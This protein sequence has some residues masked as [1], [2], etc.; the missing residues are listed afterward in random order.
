[1][2]ES[3]GGSL[4]TLKSGGARKGE[5]EWGRATHGWCGN[6]SSP[7]GS[8]HRGQSGATRRTGRT[9]QKGSALFAGLERGP[10][11]LSSAAQRLPRAGA[12]ESIWEK[13]QTENKAESKCV[14]NGNTDTW[15][16]RQ[17]G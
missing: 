5:W 17:A 1:M 6:E 14:R 11:L 9:P 8:F 13:G 3:S 10:G 15:Q 16:K 12:L 4:N 7:Q 2:L